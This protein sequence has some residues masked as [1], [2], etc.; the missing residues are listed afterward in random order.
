MNLR[1]ISQTLSSVCEICETT[2]FPES[3]EEDFRLPYQNT[4]STTAL[5]LW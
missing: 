2:R 1:Q 3:G 4:L 5:N